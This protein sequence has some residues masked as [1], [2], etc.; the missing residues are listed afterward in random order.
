MSPA[1]S[2]AGSEY[3]PNMGGMSRAPMNNTSFLKKEH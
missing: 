2:R 1:M 3:L